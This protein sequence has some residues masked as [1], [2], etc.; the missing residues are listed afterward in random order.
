MTSP[1]WTPGP[2]TVFDEDD[3]YPG[4][5]SPKLSIV[6]YDDVDGG[7]GVQGRTHEEARANARLIAAA[8]AL[9]EAAEFALQVPTGL[10]QL[11]VHL[12]NSGF[13]DGAVAH[14]ELIAHKLRAA[15]AAAGVE[16]GP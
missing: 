15:L 9:V 8:P 5:D 16:V 3:R 4:I 6:L 11:A 14:L 2:W 13:G 12:E 1:K 7:A 10:D